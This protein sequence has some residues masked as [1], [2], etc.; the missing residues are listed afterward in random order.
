MAN[1]AITNYCNLKCPYC[2]ADDMIHEDNKNMSLENYVKIL[3]YLIQYNETDIGIIG[4][5]PTL[6]PQ[7]KEILIESNLCAIEN[8]T[9][10]TLF[11][12]GINLEEYLSY[13]G[14]NIKILINCNN[15]IDEKQL[16]KF[17][18]TINHL[19]NLGWI[20]NGKVTLG[21]NLYP[22]EAEYTWIWMIADYYKIPKLRCSVVS[23][24]G[25]YKIWRNRK[26]EYFKHMKPIFINFCKEAQKRKIRL[27]LDCGHI[28]SCYFNEEELKL[29]K[30]VSC[31]THYS[32][33]VGC[34]PAMDIT[35]NL[36]VIPCFGVYKPIPIDF[37]N[38]WFG[39]TRYITQNYHIPKAL[40][41]NQSPC[42]NCDK[43]CN[44]QCQGGCL[45]FSSPE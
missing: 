30:E 33:D 4:G 16:L 28:P 10:F 5:E 1:I 37:N 34:T 22:D 7:F 13:I 36:E 21:C 31:L 43:L 41:N 3:R 25:Q 11:T 15:I 35:P 6:H 14:N 26:N 45:A 29:I 44:F 9:T 18:T 38:N 23:P 17:C 39:I 24:G 40:K 12:N 8:N 2:F 19:N 20:H 27:I 32:A 42:N